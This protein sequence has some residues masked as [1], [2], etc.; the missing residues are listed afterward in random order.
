MTRVPPAITVDGLHV[1]RRLYRDLG[2]RLGQANALN[3]LATLHRVSDGLALAEAPPA[4]PGT[5]PRH[6]QPA[7]RSPRSGGPRPLCHGPRPRHPGRGPPATS[8]RYSS[9]SA[10]PRP[11]VTDPYSPACALA[12]VAG[13]LAQRGKARDTS[14]LAASACA[15]GEWTAAVWPVLLLFPLAF[16]RLTRAL[17]EHHQL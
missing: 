4:G 15:A 12:E 14:R 10:P 5:S 13:A 2:S 16:A 17:K 1:L 8:T 11:L 7:G 3:G 9:R 6:R